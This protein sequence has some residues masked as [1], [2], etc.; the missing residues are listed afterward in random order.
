[1]NIILDDLPVN[2]A[3]ELYYTK[4]SALRGGDLMKQIELKNKCPDIFDKENDDQIYD[5]I[6][7][8]KKFQE[9]NRYQ[10]LQRIMMR[11]RLSVIRMKIRQVTPKRLDS[12]LH[13]NQPVR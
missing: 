12:M 7:Y 3:I 13:I 9:S 11:E 1:M 2:D 10:E 5:M 6:M 8:A 4:H